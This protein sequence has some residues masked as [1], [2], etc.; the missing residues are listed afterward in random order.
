MDHWA[1]DNDKERSLMKRV[2]FTAVLGLLAVVASAQDPLKTDGDKYKLVLE[3]ERV[4]VLEYRDKPGQ[5]TSLHHHPD[6]VLVA[7]GPF[8]RRLTLGDGRTQT[9]SF[10][11]GEAFA[12]DAQS[13][14]GENV[15]DTDTHVIIVELKEPRPAA[16]AK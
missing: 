15:G 13:H 11:A 8:K 7:L 14:I 10:S 16:K 6:A 4:R 12:I 2:A 5:K 3:D 9:R 1:D